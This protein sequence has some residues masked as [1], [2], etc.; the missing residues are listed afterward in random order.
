M[1]DEVMPEESAIFR[2]EEEYGYKYW[3]WDTGIPLSEVLAWWKDLDSVS[4]YFW[5]ADRLPFGKV[6]QVRFEDF[7]GSCLPY[8]HLHT[9]G[10]SHIEAD[11][12]THHHKGFDK[13]YFFR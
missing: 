6:E 12:V 4:E 7:T 5:G 13:N 2:I 3:V 11:G 8:M 9:D 10:D 1:G